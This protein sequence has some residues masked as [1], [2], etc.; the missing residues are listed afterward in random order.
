MTA[1]C[2]AHRRSRQSCR[3][4]FRGSDEEDLAGFDGNLEDYDM[5]GGED[6]YVY[7]NVYSAFILTQFRSDDML[8]GTV[9]ELDLGSDEDEEEELVPAKLKGK[10]SKQLEHPTKIIPTGSDA[11][12]DE[13]EDDEDEDGPVTMANMEARSRAMD[14]KAAREAELDAE[15]MRNAEVDT[16]GDDEFADADEDEGEEGEGAAEPFELPTAEEREEEKKAGGPQVHVVQRRMRECVRVLGNFKKR[17]AKG[18]YVSQIP[19]CQRL[20]HMHARLLL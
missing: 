19:I 10:R 11:S 2:A 20:N 14:A 5:D 18:R 1:C 6:E 8:R 9:E 12:S 13:D 17:A 16:E 4:L 15:E 7:A 3:S